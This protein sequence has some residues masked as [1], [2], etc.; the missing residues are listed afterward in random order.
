MQGG[1]AVATMM[2]GSITQ[3]RLAARQQS[4]LP[5][6]CLRVVSA[7]PARG[8]SR[9]SQQQQDLDLLVACSSAD[10]DPECEVVTEP[11]GTSCQDPE[12]LPPLSSS[13]SHASSLGGTQRAL[14]SLFSPTKLL[15][16]LPLLGLFGAADVGGETQ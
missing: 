8:A 10:R 5:K 4:T 9:S 6:P 11:A 15:S 2:S 1:R 12:V 16:V 7:H 3:T 14:Q 13:N